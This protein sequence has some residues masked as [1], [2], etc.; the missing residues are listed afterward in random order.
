MRNENEIVLIVLV[1]NFINGLSITVGANN[2]F[3]TYPDKNGI[4]SSTGLGAYG[5]I[6]PFGFGGGYYYTRL[7]YNF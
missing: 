4:V 5:Y 2:L 7:A 6:S 3:D 1:N